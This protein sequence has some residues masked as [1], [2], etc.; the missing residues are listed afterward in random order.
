LIKKLK[1]EK[2]ARESLIRQKDDD[3]RKKIEEQSNEILERNK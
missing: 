1:G 3:R 2:R